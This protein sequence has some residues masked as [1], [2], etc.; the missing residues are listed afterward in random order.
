MGRLRRW[1]HL[2]MALVVF[3]CSLEE[4]DGLVAALNRATSGP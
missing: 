2:Q 4:L 3:P 1:A